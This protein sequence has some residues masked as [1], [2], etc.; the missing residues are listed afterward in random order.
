MRNVQTIG[1]LAVGRV[2]AGRKV[3][4]HQLQE[5]C[6]VGKAGYQ[7]LRSFLGMAISHQAFDCDP[8]D[9][10]APGSATDF[11]RTRRDCY[12]DE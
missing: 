9:A 7:N 2:S 1:E 4:L 10:A 6:P 8:C 5:R 3:L 12:A 11:G